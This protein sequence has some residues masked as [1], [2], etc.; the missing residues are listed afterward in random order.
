MAW[1][2]GSR[3]RVRQPGPVRQ[4]WRGRRRCGR[5]AGAR[6]TVATGPAR[7]MLTAVDMGF[8]GASNL[9]APLPHLTCHSRHDTS[10]QAACVGCRTRSQRCD[11]ARARWDLAHAGEVVDELQ[12]AREAAEERRLVT[13]A[14]DGSSAAFEA[15]YRRHV[16]AH[17]CVVPAHDRAR[18]HRRGLHPG[19][20][21]PGLAQPAALR[22]A[23]CVRHLAAPH[24][25]QRGAAAGAP[26]ARV[27]RR[28]G[29]GRTRGRR[30][31]A[32]P[33][34]RGSGPQPR[35]RERHRRRCR[36][37]RVTSWCWSGCT[38]TR[39]RKPRSCSA[40]PSAPARHN[41]T[42]PAPCWAR[43]S[44][45]RRGTM[46][47]DDGTRAGRRSAAGCAAARA[48]AR[49]RARPRLLA[50]R[51]RPASTSA[52]AGARGGDRAPGWPRPPRRWCSSQDPRC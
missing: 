48:A 42:G 33:R 6:I 39:T 49:A 11:R 50:E 25:R 1:I 22:D 17:L 38:A 14:A 41:C 52:R 37:A 30:R 3:S 47:H 21:H 45:T 28:R 12:R 15:L 5:A 8:S 2:A 26:P 35:P 18:R 43:G 24:R 13:S 36:R 31:A 34:R 10:R 40:L 23:Q 4:P 44:A 19:S 9:L 32:R 16:A 51:S 20:L 7:S 46:T 27:P 29:F